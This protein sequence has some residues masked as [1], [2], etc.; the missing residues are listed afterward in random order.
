MAGPAV[1]LDN[2]ATTAVC[3]AARAAML[4]F[5]G[6]E[7]GNPSS[8]HEAGRR[9]RAA[10]T[11]ARGQV[12][13]LVGA[14]PSEVVFVS[15]GTEAIHLGIL[16][17]LEAA[18]DARRHAVTTAV[19]HPSVREL[20]RELRRRGRIDL[21]EVPPAGDGS[22]DAERVLAAVRDDTALVAVMWANNETGALHPVEAIAAGCRE[23]GV[24]LLLDAVQAAGKVPVD[25]GAVAAP[26][27]A[28]SSHKIHGPKGSG[29]LVVRRGARWSP[30]PAPARHEG[31]RRAGTENVPGIAGFGAAAEEALR[32][33]PGEERV[34]ALRDR[35][36]ERVLAAV[37]GAR[38]AAGGAPRVPNTACLLFPGAEGES[39]VLR[40]DAAGVAVST[41]SACTTGSTEPSPVLIAMGIP[42][43]DARGALRI[44]LSRYTTEEEIDRAAEAIAA[45]AKA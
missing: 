24:P 7:C 40:L 11:R 45:A 22:L 33:L 25:L 43:R 42:K 36:E 2:N 15:G 41:G 29:A 23:R 37:P 16:G 44:S 34:R 27:L 6:A 39:L 12:A 10:L 8:L 26:L 9:A 4:P 30:W 31:G 20:L 17:A 5:L 1:Y 21:S 32:A 38:R 13:A 14:A 35:L 28:I 3:D 19:E 18:G